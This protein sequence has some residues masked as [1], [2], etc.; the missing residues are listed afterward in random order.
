[1]IRSHVLIFLVI[2]MVGI[3][4]QTVSQ[5][6][7][8]YISKFIWDKFQTILTMDFSRITRPESPDSFKSFFH[9]PPIRQDTT[10]T[11]WVFTGISFLESEIYRIHRKKIKLSEMFIVYWE[12]IEKTK[13]FIQERGKSH[14]GQGS[15]EKAVLLRMNQYG[16][17]R[18]EDYTG[19]TDG[20]VTHNHDHLFQEIKIYLDFLKTNKIWD[21]ECYDL[22]KID[23][24]IFKR[25]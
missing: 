8:I 10:G 21:E 14:I 7:A 2:I 19:L 16:I 17:V 4:A 1:M 20:E 13:R 3:R 12:Y 9:H 5:D 22:E 23:S 24:G 6:S 15:Q 25:I 11:C 18:A